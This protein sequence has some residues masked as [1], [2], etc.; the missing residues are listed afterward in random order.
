MARLSCD[1]SYELFLYHWIV[2]NIMVYFN[3][4]QKLPWQIGLVFFVV[5]ST[6]LAW[7]SWRFVGKGRKIKKD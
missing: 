1:L 6:I 5:L 7:L 3:L 2:L 4:M